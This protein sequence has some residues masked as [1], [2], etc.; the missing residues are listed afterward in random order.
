M[1][2]AHPELGVTI[3]IIGSYKC[4]FRRKPIKPP[5]TSKALV[6]R[7]CRCIIIFPYESKLSPEIC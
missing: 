1:H 4:I 2:L 6:P 7:A 5:P 3:F